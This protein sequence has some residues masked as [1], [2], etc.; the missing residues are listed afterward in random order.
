MISR[1]LQTSTTAVEEDKG[2]VERG[3]VSSCE[4]RYKRHAIL[5]GNCRPRPDVCRIG[6]ISART[7]RQQ[8][9]R[10]IRDSGVIETAAENETQ[11]QGR[12]ASSL[13][14]GLDPGRSS[15]TE[16]NR[17]KFCTARVSRRHPY[18]RHKVL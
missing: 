8:K 14:R 17:K 12:A 5:N 15:P 11:S 4:T 13:Q 2:V 18:W 16:R 3:L 7:S 9:G 10:E 6:A 1:Q